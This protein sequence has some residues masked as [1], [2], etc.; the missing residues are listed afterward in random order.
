MDIWLSQDIFSTDPVHKRS[1]VCVSVLVPTHS[2]GGRQCWPLTLLLST[3]ISVV[4]NFSISKRF[5]NKLVNFFPFFLLLFF[6]PELVHFCDKG[7]WGADRV[8]RSGRTFIFTAP[9]CLHACRLP[10]QDPQAPLL[11]PSPTYGNISRGVR[12]Q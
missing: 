9:A 2:H 6:S 5:C 12:K 1:V 8:G 11:R 10:S 7:C 4:L 3:W